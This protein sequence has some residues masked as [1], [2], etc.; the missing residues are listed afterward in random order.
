MDNLCFLGFDCL[1]GSN[2]IGGPSRLCVK[3]M[4]LAD[5]G[6]DRVNSLCGHG[7][8]VWL[9]V[10][11]WWIALVPALF[12]LSIEKLDDQKFVIADF[13]CL[14]SFWPFITIVILCRFD[15]KQN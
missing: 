5:F 14:Y 4:Q 1:G 3:L 8:W 2:L 13:F 6:G 9:V 10:G 7:F 12:F 11:A 15:A